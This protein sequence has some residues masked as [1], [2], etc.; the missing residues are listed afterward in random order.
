MEHPAKLLHRHDVSL[1]QSA[2]KRHR[3]GFQ[4]LGT[5]SRSG[6]RE[7]GQFDRIGEWVC[8]LTGCHECL[9]GRGLI[10]TVRFTGPSI[11]S[12][13]QEVLTLSA[14]HPGAKCGGKASTMQ[15]KASKRTGSKVEPSSLPQLRPVCPQF[16]NPCSPPKR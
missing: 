11:Q 10:P 8:W 2:V 7:A 14:W 3:C 5:L 12:L 9:S 1:A 16:C 6:T 15:T 13:N 4:Q